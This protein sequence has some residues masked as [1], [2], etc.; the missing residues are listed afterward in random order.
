MQ[1]C[2]L[3]SKVPSGPLGLAPI[4]AGLSHPGDQLLCV[5]GCVVVFKGEEGLECW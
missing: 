5:D 4:R 3:V 1:R 2:L